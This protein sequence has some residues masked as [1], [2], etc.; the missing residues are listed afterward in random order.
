LRE[1]HAARATV[2]VLRQVISAGI[3]PGT[4]IAKSDNTDLMLM[5]T[6]RSSEMQV[7][8]L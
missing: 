1:P 3:T 2:P 4:G 6:F 7:L 5:L 8:F